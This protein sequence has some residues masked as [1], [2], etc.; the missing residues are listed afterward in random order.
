MLLTEEEFLMAIEIVPGFECPYC[1]HFEDVAADVYVDG[2]K[3][4][5]LREHHVGDRIDVHKHPDKHPLRFNNSAPGPGPCQHTILLVGCCAWGVGDDG[6]LVEFRWELDWDWHSPELRRCDPGTWELLWEMP[7]RSIL[8]TPLRKV[9]FWEETPYFRLPYRIVD[10]REH[11][12]DYRSV[13]PDDAMYCVQAR[14]FL[15]RDLATFV[16]DL[17]AEGF[18]A[19]ERYNEQVR[20]GTRE[21]AA[22]YHAPV[23]PERPCV[24]SQPSGPEVWLK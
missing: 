13:G 23:P 1:R 24:T 19:V 22:K 2:E 9:A 3:I 7:D 16:N 10:F 18:D 6:R 5:W 17:R 15:A 12:L 21:M 11:W 8:G 20:A 4:T 14:A